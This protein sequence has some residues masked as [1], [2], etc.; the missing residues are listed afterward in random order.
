LPVPALTRGTSIQLNER[1][2]LHAA[3]AILSST[4]VVRFGRRRNCRCRAIRGPPPSPRRRPRPPPCQSTIFRNG[5]TRMDPQ[6]LPILLAIVFVAGVMVGLSWRSLP[7]SQSALPIPQG[8]KAISCFIGCAIEPSGLGG[9]SASS[10]LAI[11]LALIR[12]SLAKSMSRT[13][14]PSFATRIGSS[15][16][17]VTCVGRTL[18]NNVQNVLGSLSPTLTR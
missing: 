2:S 1:H 12:A 14:L 17:P 11:K 18:P 8:T 5:R 15:P 6:A 16:A 4:A 7:F 10:P 9:D 3:R 13:S